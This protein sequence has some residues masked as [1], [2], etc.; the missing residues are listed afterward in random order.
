MWS[1]EQ[2]F[3]FELRMGLFEPTKAQYFLSLIHAIESDGTE[4]V[5]RRAVSLLWYLPLFLSW[6]IER[7][8]L[9]DRAELENV[10]TLV[11]NHL[12]TILGVP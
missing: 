6:Q 11:T 4:A 1:D 3:L 10:I 9:K 8:D 12:E 2:G 5:A 7:V